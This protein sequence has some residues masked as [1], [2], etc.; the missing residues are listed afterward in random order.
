ML[1]LINRIKSECIA[2]CVPRLGWRFLTARPMDKKHVM[3]ARTEMAPDYTITRAF[4][5]AD[6]FVS[7]V[8]SVGKEMNEYIEQ[9]RMGTDIMESF[10]ADAM[11]SMIVEAVV[12]YG[13]KQLIKRMSPYG[14]T[15]SNS[16]SPGYCGWHVSEQQLFFSKLPPRFCGVTLTDSSLMLPI[17]SVSTLLAVGK[18]VVEQPYGCDICHRKDCYKKKDVL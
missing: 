10:I 1:E 15:V 17:K 8:A 12:A 3:V 16:Y 14:M 13:R 2:C 11:G 5:D 18:K 4:R 9:K 6:F 7:L